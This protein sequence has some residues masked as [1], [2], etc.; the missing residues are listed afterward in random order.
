MIIQQGTVINSIIYSTRTLTGLS[1]K[2]CGWPLRSKT[3]LNSWS[4]FG[5]L[6]PNLYAVDNERKLA[7]LCKAMVLWDKQ[8]VF[9][10]QQEESVHLNL[11]LSCILEPWNAFPSSPR[12]QCMTG[13]GLWG[14]R[15]IKKVC[16]KEG[17]KWEGTI[18]LPIPTSI[19]LKYIPPIFLPLMK[20]FFFFFFCKTIH[21]IHAR[22]AQY[23]IKLN[24]WLGCPILGTGINQSRSTPDNHGGTRELLIFTLSECVP[25]SPPVLGTP[26]THALYICLKYLSEHIW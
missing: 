9:R 15:L 25:K 13:R 22:Q 21:I 19:K 26:S 6:N 24:D 3:I 7:A 18:N 8:N 12:G 17:Q 5:T 23:K 20:N 11:Y 4:G 14:E 16:R 10:V 2:L 1:E